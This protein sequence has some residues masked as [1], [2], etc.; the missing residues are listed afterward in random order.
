MKFHKSGFA[1]FVKKAIGV[2]SKALHHAERARNGAIGHGP[3]QHVSR[4]GHEGREVPEAVVG[5]CRLRKALIWRLLCGVNKVGKLDGVLYEEDGNVI[6]DDRSE[7][8]TS[9]LQ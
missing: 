8:H 4:L 6:A 7:E 2:N 5:S 3:H 1:F 9:E